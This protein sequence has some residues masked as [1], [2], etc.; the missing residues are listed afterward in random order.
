MNNNINLY[1]GARGR[2]FGDNGFRLFF[3][4][5]LNYN[6]SKTHALITRGLNSISISIT[7][8]IEEIYTDPPPTYLH[9][10]IL[11]I[12]FNSKYIKKNKLLNK[13]YG[14]IFDIKERKHWKVNPELGVVAT[15][16]FQKIYNEKT[17][18][19]IASKFILIGTSDDIDKKF[20][21]LKY[22]FNFSITELRTELYKFINSYINIEPTIIPEETSSEYGNYF[23]YKSLQ[24]NIYAIHEN[25]HGIDNWLP[26]LSL[27]K[28]DTLKKVNKPLYDIIITIYNDLKS[29]NEDVEIINDEINK[30]FI[31]IFK[32]SID[33]YFTIELLNIDIP[34]SIL[35]ISV[36]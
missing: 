2:L 8:D 6:L 16:I 17:Y 33:E 7:N 24:D 18:K 27:F 31:D 28:M 22:L 12:E 15:D 25:Y 34:G 10:T 23:I 14:P 29:K 32:K 21:A 35:N 26:H 3:V 9:F 1:G 5:V 30:I 20:I 13:L 11:D 4:G 36:S 19:L